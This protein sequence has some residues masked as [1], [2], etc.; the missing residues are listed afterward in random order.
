MVRLRCVRISDEYP[1][2]KFPSLN[3]SST[4]NM[5]VAVSYLNFMFLKY[6]KDGMLEKEVGK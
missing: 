2:S 1:H 3:I 5:N 6:F 4:R